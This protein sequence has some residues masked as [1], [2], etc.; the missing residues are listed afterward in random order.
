MYPHEW[1]DVRDRMNQVSFQKDILGSLPMEIAVQIAQ[2]LDLS[3][4]YILRRAGA[5]LLSSLPFN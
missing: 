1:R 4:S 3:D 5:P 2:Y